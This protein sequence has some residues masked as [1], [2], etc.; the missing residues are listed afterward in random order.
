MSGYEV[1]GRRRK[2]NGPAIRKVREEVRL[3]TTPDR[4]TAFA[5][6]T[7]MVA[8]GFTAW[9][10]K[11]DQQPNGKKYSLIEKLSLSNSE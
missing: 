7:A 9:V 5:A 1:Q 11:T 3:A 2:A 4:D 10:F 8:D 6:A